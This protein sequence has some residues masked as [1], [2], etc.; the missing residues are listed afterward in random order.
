VRYD[1]HAV[2]LCTA[3][4]YGVCIEP[5]IFFSHVHPLQACLLLMQGLSDSPPMSGRRYRNS[6]TEEGGRNT[7][8]TWT[9]DGQRRQAGHFVGLPRLSTCPQGRS[10]LVPHPGTPGRPSGKWRMAL[11]ERMERSS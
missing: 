6:V 5:D 11:G 9:Q 8:R 10:A 7:G 3:C 1:T 2:T 4:F